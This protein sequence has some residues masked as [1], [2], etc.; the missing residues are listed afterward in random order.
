MLAWL[1]LPLAV[2]AMRSIDRAA[3]GPALNRLLA[4]TARLALVFSVLFAF[5]LM[6]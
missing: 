4:A 3:D 2:Q 1:S 6:L 5:G